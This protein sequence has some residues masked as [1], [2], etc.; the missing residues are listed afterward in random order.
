[1]LTVS[2]V[3]AVK[4]KPVVSCQKSTHL[5][6]S[7]LNGEMLSSEGLVTYCMDDTKPDGSHPAII[8]YDT[9]IRAF[10]EL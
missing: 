1:M 3:N 9:L 7:G 5:F 10:F 2:E 4:I 8:G 6:L